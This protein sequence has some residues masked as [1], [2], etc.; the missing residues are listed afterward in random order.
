MD[1]FL[2]EG[3]LCVADAL[4]PL[5][6]A[7]AG[8][9]KFAASSSLTGL[10]GGGGHRTNNSFFRVGDY[11]VFLAPHLV[12]SVLVCCCSVLCGDVLVCVRVCVCVCV[13]ARCAVLCRVVYIAVEDER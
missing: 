3:R 8:V 5:M 12:Y 7:S 11:L 1:T 2:L 6:C 10:D 4:L 13:C 9:L